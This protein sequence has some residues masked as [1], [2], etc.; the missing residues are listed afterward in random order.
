MVVRR[1]EPQF[2]VTTP[3]LGPSIVMRV[4]RGGATTRRRSERH[5]VAFDDRKGYSHKEAGVLA[6]IAQ[7]K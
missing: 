2:E 7:R 4:A 3:R 6:L 5:A 1:P